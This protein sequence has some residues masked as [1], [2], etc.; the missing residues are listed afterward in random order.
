MVLTGAGDGYLRLIEIGQDPKLVWE[1][2]ASEF[3]GGILSIDIYMEGGG[4]SFLISAGTMSGELSVFRSRSRMGSDGEGPP[5]VGPVELL[6]TSKLHTK[7]LTRCLFAPSSDL[8]LQSPSVPPL[9]LSAGHDHYVCVSRLDEQK[10]GLDLLRRIPFL[11]AVNDIAFLGD[12]ATHI[13]EGRSLIVALKDSPCLRVIDLATLLSKGTGEED[14]ATLMSRCE[15]IV[16][17]NPHP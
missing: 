4:V 12:P 1:V 10:R 17:L 5:R 15:R 6:A 7:F 9:L 13:Q 8:S 14:E 2:K 3:S 11:A 16:G